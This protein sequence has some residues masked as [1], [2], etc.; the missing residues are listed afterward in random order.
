MEAGKA[1]SPIVMAIQK[2]E[3]GTTGEIRVHL[4]KSIFEQDTYKNA[5]R[6]FTKYRMDKTTQHNSVLIYVNLRRKKF[7]VISDSGFTQAVAPGFWDSWSK[8]FSS[9]LN[10]YSYEQAIANS[11]DLIGSVFRKS[12]AN[13]L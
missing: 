10:T 12:F 9:Q 11:I 2:A 13:D 4:S 6:V 1:F 5:L 7:A 3:E 8:T